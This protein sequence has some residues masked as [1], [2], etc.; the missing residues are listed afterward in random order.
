MAGFNIKQIHLGRL[1]TQGPW[2]RLLCVWTLA[3]VIGIIV[4]LGL[5]DMN[6]LWLFGRSPG[7]SDIKDPVVSEASE[8]YSADGV[9]MGRYYNEN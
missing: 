2:W 7:F 9:L 6:F 4:L 8:V 5:I 1:M 3:F